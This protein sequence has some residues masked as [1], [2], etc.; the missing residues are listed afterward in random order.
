MPRISDERMQAIMVES[1]KYQMV[2]AHDPTVLG[3]K[4]L[5][6]MIATCRNYT[7]HVVTLM[8]EVRRSKMALDIELRRKQAA[9]KISADELLAKNLVV[10]SLPNIKDRDA[11]INL[12]LK[13][14]HREIVSFENDILDLEHVEDFVKARHRELKDT[15]RE[16]QTQRGLIRDDRET[17]S[18]YGD[19]RPTSM[20][21]SSAEDRQ[22]AY[23]PGA[24]AKPDDVDDDDIG[25]MLRGEEDPP[26]E[27]PSEALP[28]VNTLPIVDQVTPAVVA[29]SE[30]PKPIPAAA[31][32]EEQEIQDFLDQ[33]GSNG[34][35]T[36]TG[37]VAADDDFTD[38]LNNL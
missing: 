2:L 30:T 11:Q 26:V 5:Q 16:I 14:E 23:T 4:Y 38:M 17:G 6:D 9:F 21:N 10:R 13:D 24:H 33:A 37:S 20:G 34:I 25:K 29:V 36:Q 15:M 27:A 1:E 8:N 18:M 3:P 12:M 35:P 19:E 28:E 7:N 31:K 22:T 32:T